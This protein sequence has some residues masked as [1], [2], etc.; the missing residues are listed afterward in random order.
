MP[1]KNQR[2]KIMKALLELKEQR[3]SNAAIMALYDGNTDGEYSKDTLSV[4]MDEAIEKAYAKL[5]ANRYSFR[6]SY[7]KGYSNIAFL[8][9][10]D[11]D[12][13]SSNGIPWFTEEEF[14]QHFRMHRSSFWQ[15]VGHIK[16]HEIFATPK[17]KR[18]QAPVE[19]QLLVLLMYLGTAGSGASNPRLRT[20]FGLGRG[21]VE[22]YRSRCVVAIRSL[23]KHAIQWPDEE[24]RK[25][26]QKRIYK[27]YRWPK[28]VAIADGTLFPLAYEPQS[29]D[30]PD[31]S[32]RKFKYSLTVMIVND[33]ERRIR[34]YYSGMP[35]TCHDA[36]V[37]RA[38][39]LFKH[40]EQ[41]F[42]PNQYLVADSAIP[43]SP[44]VVSAYKCPNGYSLG[45]EE[46]RFNTRLGK[47]RIISEHTIGI[48]KGR[49]PWLKSIPMVI[50]EDPSS[51]RKILQYIDCCIILHNMLIGQD[52]IP[53]DWIDDKDDTS[54]L[55]VTSELNGQ[56][57]DAS[58]PDERRRQVHSFFRDWD[59][60]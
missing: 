20:F 41:Y 21:T 4:M 11:E 40:P 17:G 38:T 15:L 22:L 34:Y 44:T 57:D 35:G 52:D 12:D 8:R 36:R 9:A 24:E 60:Y 45:P 47:L 6:N 58:P 33:D 31:Y 23:R 27:E 3:A 30:A 59:L 42:G 5:E 55:D 28:C 1:R 16:D 25:K 54:D 56:L 10:L 49:F 50:T 18:K 26:I 48:L 53:E 46:T 7:R 2:C 51:V 29:D 37:Y 13:S 32:G 14:L 43:N 39:Q 19:H